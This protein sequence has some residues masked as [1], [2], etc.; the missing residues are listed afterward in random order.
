[1]SERGNKLNKA[2]DIYIGIPLTVPAALF[3]LLERRKIDPFGIESAAVICLGAIGDLLL[4]STA[5]NALH[6]VRPGI[7]VDVYCSKGNAPAAPLLNG[8]RAVYSFPLSRLPQMIFTLRK[9]RYGLLIDTT[10]WARAGALVSAFSRAGMTVGFETTG[11]CRSMP[12]DLKVAH[13]NKQHEWRNFLALV[14]AVYPEI[15]AEPAIELPASSGDTKLPQKPYIVCHM[16]PAGSHISLKLWDEAKWIELTKLLAHQGYKV[17][18]SGGPSDR[19]ATETFTAKNFPNDTQ[20][21]SIAGTMPLTDLACLLSRADAVVSVN[22]GIMH[23]AALTGTPTVCVHGPTNPLRWGP[24]GEKTAALCSPKAAPF[25]NLGFENPP[26]EPAAN[27]KDVELCAVTEA[28]EKL[29][30]L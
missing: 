26:S 4:V 29:K 22:T 6:A 20:V 2:F 14:Q 3:R 30:V 21:S 13:S 19:A 8:V 1:M 16:W 25:L 24:V 17:L 23:L 5:I 12:Y 27:A 18:F 10:Q 9:N 11:Q 28:L 7:A 15:K